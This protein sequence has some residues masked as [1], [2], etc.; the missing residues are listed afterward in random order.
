[1][2]QW[3]E[4]FRKTIDSAFPQLMQISDAQ[5]KTAL[6][7]DHWSAKQIIG[8]LIDSIMRGSWSRN[9]RMTWSLVGTTRIDG[10]KCSITKM[11]PGR[12]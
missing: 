10:L 8:H 2:D 12:N 5:S 9:S 6:A 7:K 1:M 11:L 4:D 3:L